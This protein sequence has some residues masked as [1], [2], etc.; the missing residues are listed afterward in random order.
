MKQVKQNEGGDVTIG[1]I[2]M[3]GFCQGIQLSYCDVKILGIGRLCLVCNIMLSSTHSNTHD[4]PV[5]SIYLISFYP[6]EQTSD[7]IETG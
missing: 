1:E 4:L 3:V 5:F 2:C 7:G 6:R